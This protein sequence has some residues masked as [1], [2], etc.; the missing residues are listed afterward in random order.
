MG[1]PK[2]NN[3]R[4]QKVK[5]YLKEIEEVSKKHGLALGHEDS[6]GSFQ[7]REYSDY[8]IEWIMDATDCTNE[9]E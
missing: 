2:F 7:V 9:D 3:D 4:S 6:Q 5:N 8:N 1:S